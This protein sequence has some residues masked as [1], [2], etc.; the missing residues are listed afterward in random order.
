MSHLLSS[1]D[2]VLY[3]DTDTSGPTHAPTVY[4]L[5]HRLLQCVLLASLGPLWIVRC[6][7]LFHRAVHSLSAH[8][9][10]SCVVVRFIHR[11][12]LRALILPILVNNAT[13]PANHTINGSI[14][15][16]R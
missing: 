1:V 6:I 3:C 4:R 5:F 9:C 11:A 2:P 8:Y 12:L 16:H 10:S 7:V 14:M 13:D 15:S